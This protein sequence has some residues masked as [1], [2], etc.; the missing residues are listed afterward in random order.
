MLDYDKKIEQAYL[1]ASEQYAA[2]GVDVEAAMKRLATIAV[3]LHCWQGDDLGGFEHAGEELGGGLA[4]TGNYPGKARTADELR[5][6]LE[7]ALS[8]IPGRHRLNLHAFYAE[9]GGKEVDRNEIQPEHFQGWID[10]AKDQG[11][12]MD[13]N[14]TFSPI[15]RRTTASHCPIP[16]LV[17]ASSGSSM[18]L[19]AA[20]SAA[21]SAKP[22]TH[23]V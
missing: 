16:T 7:K 19:P 2:I 11:M 20:G 15:R 17:S 22:W 6:D 10:W 9:T 23:L 4:V 1:L 13:F 8:L 5:G 18:A 14:P 3:S 12:G 21:Q